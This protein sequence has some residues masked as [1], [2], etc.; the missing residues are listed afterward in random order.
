MK[1]TT[2]S[3]VPEI[4]HAHQLVRPAVPFRRIHPEIAQPVADIFQDGQVGE[5]VAVLVN[6]ADA[7]PLGRAIG[8]IPACHP[9]AAA[10]CPH[11]TG[12]RFE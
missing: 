9:Y 4:E 8:H 5:K 1:G 12:N 11:Q 10:R 2:P 6:D 3:Y 7:T